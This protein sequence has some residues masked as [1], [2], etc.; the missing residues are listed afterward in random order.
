MLDDELRFVWAEDVRP[1]IFEA[2]AERGKM[3]DID[4]PVWRVESRRPDNEP[5]GAAFMEAEEPYR[6]RWDKGRG[7]AERCGCG[8]ADRDADPALE[9]ERAA[10]L[11]P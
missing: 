2:D 7:D 8:D 1:V 5:D 11:G 4:S 6:R 9:A 3:E 10:T